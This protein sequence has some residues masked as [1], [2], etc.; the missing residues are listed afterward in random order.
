ME[1]VLGLMLPLQHVLTQTLQMGQC[2]NEFL[3]MLEPKEKKFVKKLQKPD[4]A[5]S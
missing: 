2:S 4:R 5:E 1:V 3:D